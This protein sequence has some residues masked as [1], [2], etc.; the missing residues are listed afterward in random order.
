MIS[1]DIVSCFCSD[2]ELSAEV[3][4]KSD[5]F[6]AENRLTRHQA[7]PVSMT[8]LRFCRMINI[9]FIF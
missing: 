6:S 9:P 4:H 2:W 3:P 1:F 5:Y 7:D 8:V